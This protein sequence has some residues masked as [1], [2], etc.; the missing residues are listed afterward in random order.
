MAQNGRNR[1]KKCRVLPRGGE[2]SRQGSL[3]VCDDRCCINPPTAAIRPTSSM[4]L[5]HGRLTPV[6]YD[7]NFLGF[8]ELTIKT[9]LALQ[10]AHLHSR[11]HDLSQRCN[12]PTAPIVISRSVFRYLPPGGSLSIALPSSKDH[13]SGGIPGIAHQGTPNLG[14]K[15]GHVPASRSNVQQIGKKPRGPPRLP[16]RNFKR[17]IKPMVP[18]LLC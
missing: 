3:P 12:R 8:G 11:L 17:G 6:V 14:A 7:T 10:Y 5:H 9:W 16:R 1:A 4:I 15:R 13:Q 2:R 18:P